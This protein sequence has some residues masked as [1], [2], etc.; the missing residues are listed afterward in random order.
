MIYLDNH[1]TTQID[2]RVL[3]TMLPYLQGK[4]GN[5]A[6]RSHLYGWSAEEA[7]DNAREQVAKLIN[8]SPGEIIFT[9]GATESNN[10][11]LQT[12]A[13]RKVYISAIEHSSVYKSC[14]HFCRW[15]KTYSDRNGTV[16]IPSF[17]DLLSDEQCDLISVMLVNNEIGTIQPIKKVREMC[18]N[19]PIHSDMA[20]ALG[21]IEVDVKDLDVDYASFSAHKVYGPK[22]VG[23]LYIK[24]GS[25]VSRFIH[26]GGQEFNLRAG[27][28]NVPGIV[29][30]GKAC[31]LAKESIHND[32]SHYESL[33]ELLKTQ[34]SELIPGIIFHDFKPKVANNLHICMPCDDMDVFTSELSER[35]AVSSGSACMSLDNKPSRVLEAVGM[36]EDEAIKSIRVG[37]GRFNTEEEMKLAAQHVAN[38]VERARG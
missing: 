14:K 9:S 33:S 15:S 19:I 28:L 20:Q 10:T 27:T 16:D 2:P 34:L 37:I 31:E 4:Y 11:V 29:G 6:S 36:S 7:I 8:A 13:N 35:V 3:D 22:G 21:K 25:N 12:Y 1:A 24:G 23:A 5:P 26:G 38:A 17:K 18:P 32:I 30:F